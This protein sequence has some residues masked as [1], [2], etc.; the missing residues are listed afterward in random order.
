MSKAKIYLHNFPEPSVLIFDL[1]MIFA[2]LLLIVALF[3]YAVAAGGSYIYNMAQQRCRMLVSQY[4]VLHGFDPSA[5]LNLHPHAIELAEF[6]FRSRR[7]S[8]YSREILIRIMQTFAALD[9]P[10]AVTC[11]R[12]LITAGLLLDSA[13][14]RDTLL[15]CNLTRS[16]DAIDV[17][18]YAITCVGLKWQKPLYAHEFAAIR[19][20]EP[21]NEFRKEAIRTVYDSL[22]KWENLARYDMTKVLTALRVYDNPHQLACLRLFSSRGKPD[23]HWILAHPILGE[24]VVSACGLMKDKKSARVMRKMYVDRHKDVDDRIQLYAD[25]IKVLAH[26]GSEFTDVSIMA[27]EAVI[28]SVI[29]LE[30]KRPNL[31]GVLE[32]VVGLHSYK[33]LICIEG[34]RDYKIAITEPRYIQFCLNPKLVTWKPLPLIT[35]RYPAMD[36]V[37]VQKLITENPWVRKCQVLFPSQQNLDAFV[38]CLACKTEDAYNAIVILVRNHASRYHATTH[39]HIEL[40]SRMAGDKEALACMERISNMP[41][42]ILFVQHLRFCLDP[43]QRT[44]T[45]DIV[46]QPEANK[47]RK[48]FR[49][50]FS[51]KKNLVETS[52]DCGHLDC[53]ICMEQGKPH[54]LHECSTC[55]HTTHKSCLQEWHK[56]H[57]RC[58][59]CAQEAH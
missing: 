58:P 23:T 21:L 37:E 30:Q 17:A 14:S 38:G 6:F 45:A 20:A 52:E 43:D 26:H 48:W 32:A 41:K 27:A 24:D 25:E 8:I 55:F 54:Q 5:C 53:V 44:S 15:Q 36:P 9:S 47:K 46:P 12:E 40:V 56:H 29:K 51:N 7:A 39:K 34:F 50:L 1:L 35:S 18:V 16:M 3:Q 10:I 11:A 57:Q 42:M 13:T 4:L 33:Q 22:S 28:Q 31:A 19:S 59:T 49:R 2:R